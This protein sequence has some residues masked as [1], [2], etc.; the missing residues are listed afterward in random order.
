MSTL[1]KPSVFISSTCYDLKQVRADLYDFIDSLGLE[2]ILSEFDTFPV[3]PNEDTIQ[4]CLNVVRDKA[5]IFVLIVGGRYGSTID[6]GISVTN[7]EYI[8]ACT[9]G[10]PKYVFIMNNVLNLLKIWKDNPKG[11]FSSAVDTPK[12]FDFI[13]DLKNNSNV[14]VLPFDTAQDI[15]R[16]L[17]IQLGY[18]FSECL[19]LKSKFNTQDIYLMQLKSKAL[20][21]A[22]E[23]PPKWSWLLFAQILQ[24]KMENFSSKRLD[25]ELG[26]G[27]NDLEPIQQNKEVIPFVKKKIDWITRLLTNLSTVFEKGFT[28]AVGSDGNGDLKRIIHLTSKYGEVY[29]QLLDWKLYF[30]GTITDPQYEH[31]MQ[32]L[33]MYSMNAIKEMENFSTKLYEQMKGIVSNTHSHNENDTISITLEL[34]VPDVSDIID[35]I[36]RLV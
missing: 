32:L 11:D 6:T 20:R 27:I 2:P 13:Y 31:L 23:K 8:E 22:V 30:A 3:N 4:N 7:L 25:V 26:F 35:E 10:A 19:L 14:W 33:S 12:L 17:K 5:D 28:K 34:T 15:K 24:D 18:L 29:N 21:I 1:K 36:K 9:K 16:T